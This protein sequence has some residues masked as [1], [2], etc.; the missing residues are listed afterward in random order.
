MALGEDVSSVEATLQL[1]GVSLTEGLHPQQQTDSRFQYHKKDLAAEGQSSSPL[2]GVS[3]L[4]RGS[5]ADLDSLNQGARITKGHSEIPQRD[6][7]R[8]EGSSS[9][10]KRVGSRNDT[11]LQTEYAPRGGGFENCRSRDQMPPPPIPIQQPFAYRARIPSL[12][13]QSPKCHH[14]AIH[15]PVTPQR[16]LSRGGFSRSMLAPDSS[17]EPSNGLSAATGTNKEQSYVDHHHSP[18]VNTGTAGPVYVRGGWQPAPRSFETEGSRYISSPNSS[19]PST[20]QPP[21]RY[22][23]KYHQGSLI[24]PIELESRTSDPS[25]RSYHSASSEGFS[26]Y[27]GRQSVPAMQTQL[28][29]PTHSGNHN[30]SPNREGR[31]TLSRTPSFVSR[32]STNKSIGLFSHVRSSSRQ[33][34]HQLAGSSTDRP[35]LVITTPAYQRPP[36]SAR[37]SAGQPAYSSPL[38]SLGGPNTQIFRRNNSFDSGPTPV[39]G[40][41]RPYSSRNNEFVLLSH[42]SHVTQ[43]R[44]R[45]RLI[46]PEA[47]RPRRRA[48]R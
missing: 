1:A 24:F 10:R 4:A 14:N 15:L 32:H 12:D 18:L 26:S 40:E 41:M 5:A 19:L 37:F 25:S 31:I 46:E 48:N 7:V 36:A 20:A 23:T 21:V 3:R 8:Q 9:K 47:S 42:D 44:D 16:H 38:P 17:M 27:H 28:E 13:W 43:K 45:G 6:S 2:N 33:I 30:P 39:N 34:N 29:S 35:Q 22:S 11:E